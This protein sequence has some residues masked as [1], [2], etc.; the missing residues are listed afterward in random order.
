MAAITSGITTKG[1][2][3][4]VGKKMLY[5]ETPATADSADTIDVTDS[6]VTGG[7]TLS[8]VDWVVC[9]DQTSGDVVTATNSSGTITIDAA[10]GTTDHTYA[11]VIIG[12]A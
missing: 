7:E 4:N 6:D 3:P 8:S 5:I 9:W 10:G 12:D 1:I 11:L 2:S